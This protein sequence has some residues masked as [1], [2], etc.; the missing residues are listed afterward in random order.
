V[1]D[2]QEFRTLEALFLHVAGEKYT[3]A[4]AWL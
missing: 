4:L 1:F 2:S 3:P